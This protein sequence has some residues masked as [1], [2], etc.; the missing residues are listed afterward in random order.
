MT[1]IDTFDPRRAAA[2]ALGVPEPSITDVDP[3]KHGLTNRSWRV[4]T[5][6]G[7]L[8][9][10]YTNANDAVLGIDRASESI[11]LRHVSAAGLGADVVLC[12]PGQ[13]LL[14]TRDLGE[15]WSQSDARV[16]DNIDR[17]ALLLRRLHE[18]PTV[19][20]I[21][22]LHLA[23]T[24]QN[25]LDVLD[26]YASHGELTA[27]SRREHGLT[28]ARSLRA[29]PCGV[30]CHNDV[31]HLN[32]IDDGHLRLIDWEY[33][34]IGEP[35]FDLASA[36]VYHRYGE[37]ERRRLLERYVVRSESSDWERLQAACWLFGYIAELWH[38]VREVAA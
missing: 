24:L 31:H 11:V 37:S 5:P 27:R 38:A 29:S 32:V 7:P 33:A 34:A 19:A 4:R 22:V 12:D 28:L 9:V 23:D 13:H 2:L 16:L 25:Y 26:R 35:L 15:T 10:R 17:L 30:L 21:R 14:I 3:I 36:C 8:V 1:Q 18:L 20:G 6:A